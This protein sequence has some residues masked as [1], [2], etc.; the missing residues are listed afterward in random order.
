MAAGVMVDSNVPL[1]I[2]KE[3]PNWFSWSA[4]S[5]EDCAARFPL[6]INPVICAEV[7][8]GFALIKEVEAALP[9]DAFKRRALPWEP[10]FLAGKC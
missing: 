5:L 7:S 6:I 2:L 10:A 1:D 4:D 9:S 3:D 8:V